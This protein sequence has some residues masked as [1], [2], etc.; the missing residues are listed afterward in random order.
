MPENGENISI[1]IRKRKV[2]R[3]IGHAAENSVAT[4]SSIEH[5]L[6]IYE[7]KKILSKAFLS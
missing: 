7:K 4:S 2:V 1:P 3:V 6:S 5:E